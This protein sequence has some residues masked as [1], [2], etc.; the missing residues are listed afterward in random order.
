[1]HLLIVFLLWVLF[2]FFHSLLADAQLKKRLEERVPKWMPF[3]RLFY[4]L[5]AGLGLLAVWFFQKSVPESQLLDWGLFSYSGLVL[6]GLGLLLGLLA[7]RN[8]SLREFS[9]LAYM[10][11]EM[12]SPKGKLNTSG[13]NAW[14]RH[15]LYFATLLIFWG[16]F[17]WKQTDVS[18]V[19]AA[20]VS[21]YL[22]VGTRLEEKKLVKAFGE[23]YKAYQKRV[24]M[25]IPFL[26]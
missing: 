8:Y 7:M 10:N 19:M 6:T 14:V 24:K 25:L 5:I 2:F 26:F 3:Y 4:N 12:E 20:A 9:G 11:G 18:L 13:M 16:W 23:D 1:M 22:L 21:L 15:P 17:V